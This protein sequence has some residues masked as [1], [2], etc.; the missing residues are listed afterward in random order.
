MHSALI[1]LHQDNFDFLMSHLSLIAPCKLFIAP[2]NV[3]TLLLQYN[4]INSRRLI[5]FTLL[6][7]FVVQL[8]WFKVPKFCLAAAFASAS[9]ASLDPLLV[10]VTCCNARST[11]ALSKIDPVCLY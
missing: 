6:S 10:L 5:D 3:L 4:A 7:G 1:H 9:L 2:S 11:A 8:I